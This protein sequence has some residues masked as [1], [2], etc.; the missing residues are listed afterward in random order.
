VKVLDFGLAKALQPDV[1]AANLSQSPTLSFAAAATQMGVIIGT[2]PYMSPEQARGKTVDKRADIWAF[3][4]VLYEMLTASRAFRGEDVSL[5]LAEVMK[6]DPEWSLLPAGATEPIRRLLRRCLDKDVRR[7]LHD[8]GDA[9]IEL[10]E[11]MAQ[12]SIAAPPAESH[13]PSWRL[14]LA[15]ALVSLLAGGL[16]SSL[17]GPDLRPLPEQQQPVTRLALARFESGSV[18]GSGVA[19]SECAGRPRLRTG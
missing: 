14:A 3:G 16:L 4:C 7:R 18:T 9:R 19:E 13:R 12:G 17:F 15:A 11:A 2:A 1:G 8:I 5:T 6:S 10:D